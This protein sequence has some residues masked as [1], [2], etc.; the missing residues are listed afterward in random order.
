MSLVGPRPPIPGEVA[1]YENW[2]RR[3]LSMRAGLTCLWQ[4][5][6]RNEVDFDDWM[7]MDLHYIDHWSLGLDLEI[8][9]KT[10]LVMIR[11]TGF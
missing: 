3:R 4:I 8:L 11:G 1:R 5:S 6:G 10:P 9:I 7:Q 2:Q